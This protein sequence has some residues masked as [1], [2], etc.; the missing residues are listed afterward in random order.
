MPFAVEDLGS[1]WDELEGAL[2]ETAAVIEN[3]DLVVTTDTA[4]AHL[5]GALGA[6]VW[7]ALP[8]VPDWRWLLERADSPWYPTAR[9]FRQVTPGDWS[10]V[11]RRMAEELGLD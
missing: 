6:R 10:E 11:F 5:A 3:L 4:L 1:T 7:I 8:H 2:V 9:L